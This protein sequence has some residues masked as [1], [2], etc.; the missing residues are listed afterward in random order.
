MDPTKTMTVPTAL[1]ALVMTI[2]CAAPPGPDA[3]GNVEATPVVVSAEAGGRLLSFTPK[4]GDRLESGAE[5]G[6]VESTELDLERDRLEAQ[7]NASETHVAELAQQRMAAEAQREAARAQLAALTAQ[8][9]IADRIYQR[10]QRL[11]AEQAAT[12]QQ[13]DQAEREFR[14]LVEQIT[15]QNRQIDAQGVQ[16]EAARLAERSA[17][18]QVAALAAQLAQVAERLGKTRIRSTVGG[19]VLT[20]YVKAGEVVQPGQPLY[21]IA[22]LAS[23]EVRAYVTETQLSGLKIGQQAQVTVDGGGGTHRQLTGAVSWISS[24]AEFTPTPIQTRDERVNLVYA[25]KIR[26][27]NPDGVLKIGMPADVV[28]GEVAS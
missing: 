4:E 27:S 8:R 12:A 9:E 22:D 19:T 20:T 11:S 15:A 13:V 17:R 7:R 23:L 21:R 2:G 28:F 18:Q 10:V 6:V 3:Y 26:V 25:V 16:I 24:E 14:V 5:V 1:A